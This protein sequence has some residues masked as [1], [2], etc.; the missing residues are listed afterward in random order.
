MKKEAV[1]TFDGGLNY[2]VNP[3]VTPNNILTDCVNGTFITFNGDE[4]ALQNDSGNSKILVKEATEESPAEYAKLPEEY[5]P[6]AVKEYGGVLY[7]IS[8]DGTNIQFGSYPSPDIT[9]E[10]GVL[11][12]KDISSV[13]V[14]YTDLLTNKLWSPGDS[15]SID[16]NIDNSKLYQPWL[17]YYDIN[18]NKW[19][20]KLYKSEIVLNIGNYNK[21][22]TIELSKGSSYGLW[23]IPS[24]G[25]SEIILRNTTNLTGRLLTRIILEPLETWGIKNISFTDDGDNITINF[26]VEWDSGGLIQLQGYTIYI[27]IEG[28]SQESLSNEDTYEASITFSGKKLQYKFVPIFIYNN[29]AGIFELPVSYNESYIIQGNLIIPNLIDLTYLEPSVEQLFL[30]DNPDKINYEYSDTIMN[31]VSYTKYVSIKKDNNFVNLSS[32]VI[33]PTHKFIFRHNNVVDSLNSQTLVGKWTVEDSV[34]VTLE[35]SYTSNN[36]ALY[37]KD[38]LKE[39]SL[40]HPSDEKDYIVNLV[41]NVPVPFKKIN[42]LS[43]ESD[44]NINNNLILW[45]SPRYPIDAEEINGAIKYWELGKYLSFN[46]NSNTW[47]LNHSVVPISI[48]HSFKVPKGVITFDSEFLGNS[49]SPYYIPSIPGVSIIEDVEYNVAVIDKITINTVGGI[50]INKINRNNSQ[51]FICRFFQNPV[52]YIDVEVKWFNGV[53]CRINNSPFDVTSYIMVEFNYGIGHFD[54]FTSN[55]SFINSLNS[56]TYAGNA[57]GEIYQKV[58]YIQQQR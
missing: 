44:L 29:G 31:G 4:L 50:F 14:A 56:G 35:N 54:P 49:N 38:K 19:F 47:S 26:D 58:L 15:F 42:Y 25:G 53:L 2:D 46:S 13:N 51:T 18:T 11:I 23:C 34:E 5:Y 36:M 57:E 20:K 48:N 10:N 12:N 16:Y 21:D 3:L 1:N 41:F 30:V 7:I 55:T 40:V 27:Q 52:D 39:M 37:L 6:L 45:E 22:L 33:N 17:S 32:E 28:Q 8:T 24:S 9:S 43:N